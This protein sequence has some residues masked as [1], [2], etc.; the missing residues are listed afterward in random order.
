MYL[1]HPKLT[2]T[3]SNTESDRIE[4]LNRVYG[5]AVSLAD[6]AGNKEFLGKLSHLHDHKGTLTVVWFTAPTEGEQEFFVR[7][8]QSKIGD[9]TANVEHEVKQSH[10]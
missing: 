7:A 4:R 9:E 8:W 3:N 5:Y 10:P 2:A 6:Q 1:D